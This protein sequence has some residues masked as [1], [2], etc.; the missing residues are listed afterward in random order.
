MDTA[1]REPDLL[2]QTVVL[3]GGSAGIGFATAQRARAEAADVILALV[4]QLA[5][6][7]APVRVDLIAPGLV[8]TPLAASFLGDDLDARREQLMVQTET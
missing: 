5:L 6:D 8:D 4:A 3:I 7:I 1:A 2:G